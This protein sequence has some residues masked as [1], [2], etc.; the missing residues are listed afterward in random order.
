[1]FPRE[2]KIKI[3][4]NWV[5]IISPCSQGWQDVMLQDSIIA[6]HQHW[7]SGTEKLLPCHR[8]TQRKSFFLLLLLWCTL[9]R[10]TIGIV[11]AWLL[12]GCRSSVVTVLRTPFLCP[13]SATTSRCA[14]AITV[15]CFTLRHSQ[16]TLRRHQLKLPH[17]IDLHWL[18]VL[19]LPR[20]RPCLWGTGGLRVFRG[21]NF[22]TQSNPVYADCLHFD[23]HPIQV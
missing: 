23:P 5:Q 21:S 19:S 22:Q 4:H 18:C 17:I 12:V 3:I 11:C 15:S 14:S 13:T 2:L 9:W 10:L 7:N 20:D 6:L 8:L 1:M 16:W